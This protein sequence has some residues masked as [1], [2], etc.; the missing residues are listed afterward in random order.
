MNRLNLEKVGLASGLFLAVVYLACVAFD[1]LYPRMAMY[2]VWQRLLPGFTW[3]TPGSFV[4][5]LVESFFYGIFFAIVF[6]M[7]YDSVGKAFAGKS[8]A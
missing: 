4:L 2:V 1:L 7:I 8:A 5:G 6:A 3:L